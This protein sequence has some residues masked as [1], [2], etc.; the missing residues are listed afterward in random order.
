MIFLI[1]YDRSSGFLVG[2]Q[3][4]V[5]TDLEKAQKARL[6]LELDR[7]ASS[8]DREIVILEAESEA[9]LRRTHRRYFEPLSV[10]AIPQPA[11]MPLKAA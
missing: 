1:E 8:L 10:L 3:P 5:V 11:P 4:F 9:Q 2:V 7:A 6:N